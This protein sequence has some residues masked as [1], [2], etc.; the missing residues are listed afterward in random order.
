[1]GPNQKSAPIANR[2]S[3]RLACSFLK[4]SSS[5]VLV[6]DPNLI[7]SVPL[8]R[9]DLTRAIQVAGFRSNY[10]SRHLAPFV[11]SWFE[12]TFTRLG[13]TPI[14]QSQIMHSSVRSAEQPYARPISP[15]RERDV[16][17]NPLAALPF[18][19]GLSPSPLYRS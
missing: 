10:P 4:G 18:F 3:E 19:V 14:S 1:M 11:T 13:P 7:S 2:R 5:T 9:G 12:I 8:V 17:S 16:G 6:F 15:Q